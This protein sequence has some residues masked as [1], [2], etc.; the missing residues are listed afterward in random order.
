MTTPPLLKESIDWLTYSFRGLAHYL[1]GG[2]KGSMQAHMMPEK[3]LR[4]FT[5]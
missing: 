3:E 4:V 5:S 1:H 2:K